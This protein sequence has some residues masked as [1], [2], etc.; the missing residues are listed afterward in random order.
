LNERQQF[1][2]AGERRLERDEVTG[3]ESRWAE[4]GRGQPRR[5]VL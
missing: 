2:D 4:L 1:I 3:K 5:S